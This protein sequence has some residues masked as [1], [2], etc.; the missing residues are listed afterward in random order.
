MRK[1][2]GNFH[3]DQ[4][5]MHTN[6]KKLEILLKFFDPA[7][8]EYLNEHEAGNMYFVYRWL[9][10]CFKRELSYEDTSTLWEAV[11]ANYEHVDYLLFFTIA[12]LLQHRHVIMEEEL[13]FDTL[14]I[15]T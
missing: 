6:F 3:E 1:I 10:L 12:I 2:G 8:Y 7:F 13:E 4:K 15:V 9:L 11:W 14:L 5:G